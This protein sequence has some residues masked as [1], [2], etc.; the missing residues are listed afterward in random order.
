MPK[1]NLFLL[2]FAI[3]S[4]CSVPTATSSVYD[5]SRSRSIYYHSYKEMCNS[6]WETRDKKIKVVFGSQEKD[7]RVSVQ[8]TEYH[9]NPDTFQ[10]DDG[11]F[12]MESRV[13]GQYPDELWTLILS[14]R[15]ESKTTSWFDLFSGGPQQHEE[16]GTLNIVK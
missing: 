12:N 3:L 16:I 2:L 8:G 13:Q 6:T 14:M 10:Y 1:N 15:P 5:R 4:S 11:V 7:V 9:L